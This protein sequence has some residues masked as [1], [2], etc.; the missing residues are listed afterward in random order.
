M[1]DCQIKNFPTIL[2]DL[3]RTYDISSVGPDMG[4]SK[5]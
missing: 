5:K 4:V 1:A 2:S 3:C